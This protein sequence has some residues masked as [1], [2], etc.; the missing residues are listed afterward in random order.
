MNIINIIKNILYYSFLNAIET[1]DIDK[2]RSILENRV[3]NNSL[4]DK[5]KNIMYKHIDIHANNEYAF[6]LAYANN[7]FDAIKYLLEF[8]VKT[9]S[10]I[11]IHIGSDYVICH[12][13]SSGK[14]EMVKYLL[15]YCYKINDDF[16]NDFYNKRLLID[17]CYSNNLEL[18]KYIIEHCEMMNNKIQLEACVRRLQYC[19]SIRKPYDDNILD[20]LFYLMKHNYNI[21]EI[22]KYLN[23]DAVDIYIRYYIA[24]KNIK[25]TSNIDVL[26]I[27]YLVNN[28]VY[29]NKEVF[30]CTIYVDT[31]YIYV[32]K[33]INNYSFI[34]C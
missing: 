2:I 29:S 31:N 13:C 8:G 28:M 34:C 20:Y 1:C 30:N 23:Y 9:N 10:K 15:E 19:C 14:I 3:N 18:V 4:F 27:S 11:N 21:G 6:L 17:S 25:H 5:T 16:S 7:S 26:P 24:T 22:Y 12:M 33:N 32:N